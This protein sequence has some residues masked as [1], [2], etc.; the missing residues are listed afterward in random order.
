MDTKNAVQHIV[1]SYYRINNHYY[2]V[3]LIHATYHAYLVHYITN[4]TVSHV[5]IVLKANRDR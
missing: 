5:K 2:S 4:S 1:H 3:L